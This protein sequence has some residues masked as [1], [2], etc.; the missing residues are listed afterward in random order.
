MKML[1]EGKSRWA[2]R[3]IDCRC[4]SNKPWALPKP[5]RGTLPLDPNQKLPLAPSILRGNSLAGWQVLTVD[6]RTN[7][8]VQINRTYPLLKIS[9]HYVPV[10]H[11]T[12]DTYRSSYP[13]PK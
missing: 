12:V 7:Q 8:R 9:F 10:R 11:L 3:P 13:W 1:S 5:T 4:Q 2:N 6:V